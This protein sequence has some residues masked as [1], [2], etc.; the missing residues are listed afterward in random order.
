M[1]FA[2]YG[3]GGGIVWDSRVEDEYAEAL[4]K[5]RILAA[6]PAGMRLLETLLWR[7]GRGWFLLRDHLRRLT[8]S[9]RQLGFRCDIAAIRRILAAAVAGAGA[10]LRV[11]LMLSRSGEAVVETA[12]APPAAERQWRV[13]IARA[14]VDFANPL[15]HH[16]TTCRALYRSA[17]AA[18]PGFDDVLLWNKRGELTEATVANLA[19]RLGGR[20]YTPP[21]ACGLLPGV[22]RA[23]LLRTG[24][25]RER[26]LTTCDLRFAE[27]LAL[28]NSLRGWMAAEY[29]AP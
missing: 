2:E 22:Y 7:P 9:A 16:K 17:R 15:L 8:A 4:V 20:W 11:R 5:S 28:F 13:T 27:G 10:P 12:P 3:T 26:T 19:L 18:R 24:R 14:P 6:P 29:V 23:H 21:L 25:I 1:A